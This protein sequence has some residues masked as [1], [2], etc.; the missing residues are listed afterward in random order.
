MNNFG[1]K[2][3]HSS[4]LLQS[5]KTVCLIILTEGSQDKHAVELPLLGVADDVGGVIAL[6][7]AMEQRPPEVGLTQEAENTQ[8]PLDLQ[9]GGRRDTKQKVDLK[10]INSGNK[11]QQNLCTST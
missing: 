3:S 4:I 7:R 5:T 9:D 2:C 1:A 10:R 11:C 6:L 8:L